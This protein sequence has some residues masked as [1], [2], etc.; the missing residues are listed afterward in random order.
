MTDFS[1]IE[2]TWQLLTTGHLP[3]WAGW[4]IAALLGAAVCWQL[5]REL[6]AAPSRVV[7]RW[8][9]ALRL[10]VVALA[11]WLLCKPVLLVTDRWR[12]QPELVTMTRSRASFGSARIS[13]ERTTPSMSWK[14][15]RSAPRRAAP[16]AR[17]RSAMRWRR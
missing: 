11:V 4:L 1:K 3:G 17:P 15:S 12:E 6:A 5:Q 14:R 2:R 7:V 9:F 10:G 16:S 8:L 13:A